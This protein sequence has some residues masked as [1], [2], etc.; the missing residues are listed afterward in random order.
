M[1]SKNQK[2]EA[3]QRHLPYEML[4]LRH[5]YGRIEREENQLIWNMALE[6]FAVHARILEAFLTKDVDS[7]NF[8]AKDFSSTFPAIKDQSINSKL[9]KL[10]ERVFHLGKQRVVHSYD[11]G[12]AR[13]AELLFNWIEKRFWEFVNAL[14]QK[15]VRH[16]DPARASPEPFVTIRTGNA[17]PSA[18]NSTFSVSTMGGMTLTEV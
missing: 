17:P 2:I 3:L 11:K 14:D 8:Q 10:N 12:G 6:S 7:R 1:A 4:M 5:T 9:G 13:D 16:W 18:T 15:W